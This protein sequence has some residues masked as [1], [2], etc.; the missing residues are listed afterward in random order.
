MTPPLVVVLGAAAAAPELHT[1]AVRVEAPIAEGPIAEERIEEAQRIGEAWGI[2]ERWFEGEQLRLALIM[3]VAVTTAAA[4]AIRTI[5]IA[6]AA[7]TTV[8]AFI[9]AAQW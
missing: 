5:N 9:L 4:T 3:G 1:P 7:A 2:A 8:A 6:V